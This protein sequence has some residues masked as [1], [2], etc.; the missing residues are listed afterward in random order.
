MSA[1]PFF[2]HIAGLRGIAIL[3]VF[4]FHL[5][6]NV[7]PH[8][9][10]G[11]DIF[12]VISG[13]LLFLSFTRKGNQL[14]V[15]EFAAKKLYRIFPPM[16]II[17]LLT[18]LAG[19]HFQDC[20][21]LVFTSRTGRYTLFGYVN[22]F[23]RKNQDDYFANDALDN[24]F[25]HMWYLSVTIH[26]YI[27]FAVGCVVYRFIPRLLSWILLWGIG[28]ASFCY[29]YSYQIHNILQALGLP[30]WE[31][32]VPV[33]HYST[34]PRV[35]EPL[36]GGA[37]LMLPLTT[38]KAKATILT[39]AGLV[40]AIIPA[41]MPTG[42]ADYGVPLVVLG[43][44]LIVRYMPESCLMPLLANKLL[45]WIGGISFSLYLVHM[46]I[47]A[48]FRIWYQGINGM[49][50]YAIITL[51]S[52]ILAWVFWFLVEKRHI[53]KY[54]TIALWGVGM[55]ICVLG[56]EKEGFKDY[57]YPEINA[58][59]IAPYDDWKFCSPDILSNQFDIANMGYNN[60]VAELSHSTLKIPRHPATPL[61]QMGPESQ[62]PSVL[63]I[64]DSH[65]QSA[66]FG[67]NRLL[68]EM[69]VPGVFLSSIVLP[70]WDRYHWLNPT[71]FYGREK[72][73]ALLKWI[74]A[75][76]SITHVF[77][78]QY[79]RP[80]LEVEE[81]MHWDYKK[82]P[83][84]KELY[85]KSL[86]E[87]IQKIKALDKHVV[88]IGPWPETK[89]ED[90]SRYVR[91]EARKGNSDV[92]L[93]PLTCTRSRMIELNKDITPMLKSLEQE[94]LCS[95][96]YAFDYISDDK[97]FVAYRN[98]TFLLTDDDHLSGEGS[99]DLFKYLR[100]QIEEVLKEK[101]PSIP[102]P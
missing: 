29:G 85:F 49:G 28:I 40:A 21:D 12:L 27:M 24:P 76:P 70:F 53:N 63:L 95:V 48:Y 97:P 9:F 42:V 87:F 1:Q 98:G 7:F 39:L 94:G 47:I 43:T 89:I 54:A 44:M 10:Y 22:D 33:S 2:N 17:V 5:C 25:L 36:A 13:Y 75:N 61:M 57:I 66:Y 99:T 31:Q 34:L 64:G 38:N 30:V 67:M 4:L 83:M 58:I 46:P 51:L 96:L 11:V 18:M 93:E 91:I 50:D 35:W 80:R 59:R 90:P 65:A 14:D 102:T 23:L 37:I 41:L 52:F 8:G 72:A 86:R 73:E 3:L 92:N 84:S 60:G 26:L 62:T 77:I 81:H 100:P 82:E 20:E 68:G 55:T 78:G 69:N 19:M 15:K 88:L 45:L 79:W 16:V 6:T 101:A 56:K 74:K 71:Y 32:L